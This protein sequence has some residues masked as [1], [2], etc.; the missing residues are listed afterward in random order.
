MIEHFG[1]LV[2][3][4]LLFSPGCAMM[5]F[6]ILSYIKYRNIYLDL[7]GLTYISTGMMCLIMLLNINHSLEDNFF[8]ELAY[9]L[10][11][12]LIIEGCTWLVMRMFYD[13][14]HMLLKICIFIVGIIPVATYLL[15]WTS[16][17]SS[18]S[19][20]YNLIYLFFYC[21]LAVNCIVFG[22]NF[23][24]ISN[25][26]GR[27]LAVSFSIL[28]VIFVVI[29]IA[30]QVTEIDFNPLYTFYFLW[31]VLLIW[32]SWRYILSDGLDKLFYVQES[33]VKRFDIT[34]REEEIIE[35][36]VQGYKN[37]KIG[38]M[39]FISEKTVTNHIYNIYKKLGINSRFELIC[40]FK[41]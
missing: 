27:R 9:M 5:I 34:K 29:F 3:D 31:S 20:I 33:F 24:K 4:L 15:A 36:V 7:F 30:K 41:Q 18:I 8:A 1:I 32:F 11:I 23:R 22:L 26:S 37:S 6:M 10:C 19:T 40:L 39:L 14:L 28:L 35:L 25:S 21:V 13:K 12:L 2:M 17:H 38:E 16:F